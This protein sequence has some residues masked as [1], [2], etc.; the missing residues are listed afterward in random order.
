MTKKEAK[1]RKEAWNKALMEGR[2]VRFNDGMEFRSFATAEAAES[3]RQTLRRQ[4]IDAIIV[5]PIVGNHPLERLRHHVT[6]AIERG[7]K[8]AIVGKTK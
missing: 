1:A 8:E 4:D 5:N 6:G 3:F 2:V 7:E